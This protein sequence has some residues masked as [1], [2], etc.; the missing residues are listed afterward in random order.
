MLVDDL[1][2]LPTNEPVDLIGFKDQIVFLHGDVDNEADRVTLIEIY[3]SLMELAERQF[4]AQGADPTEIR[5]LKNAEH[6]FFCI[7]EAT[8]GENVDPDL[9]LQVTQR[10]VDAGR[11]PAD[12]GL[13]QHAKDGAAVFGRGSAPERKGFF[14]KL[15]GR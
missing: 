5:N 3:L 6:K 2:S 7:K 9:L 1:R 15:F 11:L 12:D 4:I 14:N 10:E 13:Y 8:I